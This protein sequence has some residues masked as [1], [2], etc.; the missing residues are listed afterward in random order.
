MAVDNTEK[1]QRVYKSLVASQ[2]FAQKAF[3]NIK[4]AIEELDEV[5]NSRIGGE[6]ETIQSVVDEIESCCNDHVGELEFPR[7]NIDELIKKLQRYIKDYNGVLTQKGIEATVVGSEVQQFGF[8]A[9]KSSKGVTLSE[10][11]GQGGDYKDEYSSKSLTS[12]DFK[13]IKR[14]RSSLP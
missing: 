12:Q 6:D 11:F 8:S 9:P 4:K 13:D 2:G 7:N 3:D 1:H 5:V 14:K 10:Q